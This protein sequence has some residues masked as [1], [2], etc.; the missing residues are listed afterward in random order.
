MLVC[1]LLGWFCLSACVRPERVSV[2]REIRKERLVFAVKEGDTLSL[3]KYECPSALAA[4]S[5]RPV[6]IFAFGGGFKGGDKAAQRYIP[7]FE[8]LARNGFVVVSTDYRTLLG[9]VEPDR[10]ATPAAF[11]QSLTQAIDTAVADFYTATRFVIERA[12]TWNIDPARIVASGSSAGAIT[13]LQAEYYLA[14]A[15]SLSA[16]LPDGFNYAG[17][18]AFA[19]AVLEREAPRWAKRPC[20]MML[21]HGDADPVVPYEKAV[22]EPFGGLWGSASIAGSLE[23]MDVPCYFYR[24]ANAGHEIADLPMV[25]NQYDVLSFLSRCVLGRERLR[26]ETLEAVPGDSIAPMRFTTR[27]YI[28]N[29]LPE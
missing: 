22:I 21:F 18:V 10:M 13:V 26:I 11:A 16:A 17:V 3:D 19:G 20:P 7:Y 5:A 6:M 9:D 29:N 1:A 15:A 8:R 25:R 23:A 4:D 14:N 28:R 12:R 24:V 27:D 2:N